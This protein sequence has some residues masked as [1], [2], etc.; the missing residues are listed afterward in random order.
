M[1]DITLTLSSSCLQSMGEMELQVH[2]G[3]KTSMLSVKLDGIGF[4]LLEFWH[5]PVSGQTTTRPP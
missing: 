2:L 1:G 3:T 5:D 4:H